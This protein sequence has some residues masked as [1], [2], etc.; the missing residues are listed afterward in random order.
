M[1]GF[2]A[3]SLF[4]ITLIN[5]VVAVASLGEIES[6]ILR[7]AMSLHGV[8]AVESKQYLYQRHRIIS[9]MQTVREFV[10]TRGRVF[11]V[12]WI[13]AKTPDLAT[14]LGTYYNEYRSALAHLRRR[15]GRAP[16]VIHTAHAQ[17]EMFGHM[18]HVQGRAH[19]PQILPKGAKLKDIQ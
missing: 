14:V 19:L 15:P 7:D 4:A 18:G 16:M 10:D 1:R 12:T 6:S 3:L 5:S 8:H 11:A 13:G 9:K 2:V 17:I